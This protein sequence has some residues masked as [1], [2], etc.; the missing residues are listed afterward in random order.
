MNRNKI[1]IM[2]NQ[3][4]LRA[5]DRSEGKDK[6]GVSEKRRRKEERNRIGKGKK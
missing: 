1:F 6:N 5:I 4:I 3:F 2:I